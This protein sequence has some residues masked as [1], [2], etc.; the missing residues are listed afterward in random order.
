[1]SQPLL[2]RLN[3]HPDP[4]YLAI[5]D[6]K[7]AAR[8]DLI[9]SKV[10]FK[11]KVVLDLGCSGG[12][13][14]FSLTKEAK[15][16]IAIDG[17]PEIIERNK[18]IRKDL[19]IENIEFIQG[20]ISRE[21]I[22]NL[23][24]IDVTLFLSVYHHMLAISDAYDWNQYLDANSRDAFIDALN[25]KTDVLIFEIGYPNEGYEWCN[26]LPSYEP[27]WDEYVKQSVFRGKYKNVEVD[28]P[29]I[30]INWFNK[31]IVS[32]LSTPYKEDSYFIEKI[33]A[34][35]RFDARDLRRI[36]FGKK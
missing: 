12:F 10:D 32:K 23:E 35:F 4:R 17:D 9:K 11:N 36:Y 30:K 14:S 27:N 24:K 22:D 1:M 2:Q 20:T 19:A 21:L 34:L 29:S 6:R 31:N 13:F 3:Y 5:A 8:L 33:K 15:K 25:C 18:K 7:V 26:R 16:I 28:L